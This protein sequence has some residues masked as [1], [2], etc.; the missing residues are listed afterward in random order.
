MN[1]RDSFSLRYS[2]VRYVT[3]QNSMVQYSEVQYRVI[4]SLSRGGHVLLYYCFLPV[5]V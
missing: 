5:S 1:S 4:V 2:T 3:V